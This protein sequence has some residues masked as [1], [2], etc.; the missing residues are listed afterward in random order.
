MVSNTVKEEKQMVLRHRLDS[1]LQHESEEVKAEAK[2][3][4]GLSL[5]DL[6]KFP[7]ISLELALEELKEMK[8]VTTITADRVSK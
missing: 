3:I 8:E 1:L 4:I 5:E 7:T 2:L 6:S